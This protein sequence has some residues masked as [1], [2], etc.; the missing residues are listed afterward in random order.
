MK[1]GDTELAAGERWPV[2]RQCH[3]D[4]SGNHAVQD[5]WRHAGLVPLSIA[6]AVRHP[7]KGC[8][9]DAQ[10]N[11]TVRFCV[12]VCVFL[13]LALWHRLRASKL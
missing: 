11:L 2:L 4:G 1:V 3:A 8:M 12:C 6:E 7:E 13:G 9:V 5:V 10:L